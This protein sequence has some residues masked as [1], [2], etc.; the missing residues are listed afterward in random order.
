MKKF[1]V[2]LGLVSL[3][4]L[5]NLALL[6]SQAHAAVTVSETVP[7]QRGQYFSAND[8]KNSRAINSELALLKLTKKNANF[9]L[10]VGEVD[11]F[12]GTGFKNFEKAELKAVVMP[13]I[14]GYT[15]YYTVE[16]YKVSKGKWFMFAYVDKKGTIKDY[17]FLAPEK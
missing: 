12:G 3:L 2:I 13:G 1:V 15:G 10:V 7:A 4:G 14:P 11:F 6:P 5:G 16:N 17:F 8:V 9:D